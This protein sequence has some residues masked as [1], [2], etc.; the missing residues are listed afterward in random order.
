MI[1]PYDGPSMCS[2]ASVFA[3][4]GVGDGPCAAIIV[5]ANTTSSHSARPARRTSRVDRML[6]VIIKETPR[7]RWHHRGRVHGH[8]DAPVEKMNG[9]DEQPFIGT[10]LDQ[11][12][13]DAGE[14]TARDAHAL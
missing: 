9:Q 11:Q 5:G 6:R 14:R 13:F 1:R 12:T 4:S 8:R 10:R 2:A 3:T 7:L